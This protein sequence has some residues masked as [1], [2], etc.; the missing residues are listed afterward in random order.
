MYGQWGGH[1]PMPSLGYATGNREPWVP[2]EGARRGI[3]PSLDF[4]DIT[5]YC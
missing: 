2:E 5:K 4:G 3:N 1:G